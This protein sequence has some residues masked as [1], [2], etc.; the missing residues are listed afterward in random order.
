MPGKFSSDANA[1]RSS[2]VRFA[3]FAAFLGVIAI[4]ILARL[5]IALNFRE[6]ASYDTT[7]FILT[8]Q[9]IINFDFSRYDGRRTPVYPLLLLLA[10]M[11][12]QVV[13]WIQCALGVAVSAMMF[14]V[15]WYRT[16]SVAISFIVGLL[17]SLALSEL[18]YEQII[19][20]ETLCTFFVVLS[21]LAFARIDADVGARSWNYALLGI[22]AALAGMT[23]P[24]F[25]FLGPIYFCFMLARGRM[26]SALALVL[27]P[28]L[29][30][31]IGWSAFNQHTIGYFGVTTTTGF[32]LSNHSG[33]FME[34]APSR[35]SQIA[36]IYLRYRAWQIPR[37][38]SQTMTIW[39][40]EDEIKRTTGLSTAQ[41]SKQLTRMSL[42]MFAHHPLLYLESGSRAWVRFW[43]FH[44][45]DFIGAYKD[46]AGSIGYALLLVLGSF[47]LAINI[48]FLIVALFA[49]ARWM[50][51]RISFDFDLGIIAI[52]LAGSVVQAFLEYGENVRYLAPLVP[53]TIY[54]TAT[55]LL[56]ARVPLNSE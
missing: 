12:W 48:A 32:N 40:A 10:G 29:V 34:L 21:M 7:G 15:A 28:T 17:S 26:R 13:R 55:R 1:Q 45:Y 53:L 2:R 39:L 49:L 33:A 24:M 44:F 56:R 20:S 18:L 23:R 22:A 4:S 37:M 5:V 41:L 19:Y 54:I 30:L 3:F 46:S 31:A 8:A 50:L 16:R 47:Q 25:L 36:D 38:G 42:E 52:V 11:D 51:G 35:Y 9:A 6:R 43:G 27:A 14:R